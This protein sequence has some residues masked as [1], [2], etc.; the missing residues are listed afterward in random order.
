NTC[1]DHCHRDHGHTWVTMGAST[2]TVWENA[3]A[4]RLPPCLLPLGGS[5]G[6]ATFPAKQT[7]DGDRPRPGVRAQS[8]GSAAAPVHY[9]RHER[10]RASRTVRGAAGG[11]TVGNGGRCRRCTGAALLTEKPS[12]ERH[13]VTM[14]MVAV[15]T[16]MDGMDIANREHRVQVHR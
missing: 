16:A 10:H 2:S 11:A 8:G 7:K 15:V 12:R 14:A 6:Y 4:Y 5:Q 9:A 3:V 13:R 1:S